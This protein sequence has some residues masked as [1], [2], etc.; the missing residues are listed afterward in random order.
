MNIFLAEWRKLRRPTLLISTIICVATVSAFVTLMI[1]R[2]AKGKSIDSLTG[3]TASSSLLGLIAFCVF[4]A[5]TSQEYSFGTLRNLLVREPN[6]IKLILGKYVAMKI[7]ISLIILISLLIAYLLA[8]VKDISIL[9][10]VKSYLNVLIS[11]LGYGIIGMELGIIF[12]SQV[13]AISI[14]VGWLL[15]VESIIASVWKASI[16]WLPSQLLAVVSSG[17]Q[18]YSLALI[19]MLIFLLITGALTTA[20]FAKRDVAN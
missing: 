18:N 15:V 4:A 11:S 16:I 13:L 1:S 12:R 10:G 14:G 5:Q 6:R 19:K 20:I 2:I 8:P 3:F 7:F 9:D 17:G